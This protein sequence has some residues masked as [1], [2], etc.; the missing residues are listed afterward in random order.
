LVEDI[1]KGPDAFL[2]IAACAYSAGC[3]AL[4][5]SKAKKSPSEKR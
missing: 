3:L 1:T 4:L 2:V 5:E